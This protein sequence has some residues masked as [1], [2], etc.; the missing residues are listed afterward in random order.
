MVAVSTVGL[1]CATTIARV[2]GQL[3][4]HERA[5]LAAECTALGGIH[6]I[7]LMGVIAADN[8]ATLIEVTDQRHADGT[9]EAVVRMGDA[10]GTA[11]AFDT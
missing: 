7:D 10:N 3:I 4:V 11:T 6:D 9:I 8:G 1:M 5:R 2:G